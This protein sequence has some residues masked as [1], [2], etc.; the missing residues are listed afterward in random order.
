MNE[1]LS[2]SKKEELKNKLK[3][4]W[5]TPTSSLLE[6]LSNEISSNFSNKK[7]PWIYKESIKKL[8]TLKNKISNNLDI[9]NL[10]DELKNLSSH[11]SEEKKKEFI[12][13]IKWAKE[14]LKNSRDLIDDIKKDLNIFKSEDWVFSTKLFWQNLLHRAK[15]PQNITDEIIWWWIWLFNSSEAVAKISIDLIIWIWKTIPDIY[16][17][18]SW[19]W[20][21]DWFKDI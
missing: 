15:N 12:L 6:K 17:I 14:I 4:S 8:L 13:A 5:N 9:P 20:E 18:I 2:E 1:R 10:E 16:K 21:Y 11:L 19:K 3:L 7:N